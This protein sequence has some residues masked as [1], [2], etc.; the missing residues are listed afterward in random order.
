M[1]MN[2]HLKRFHI[3]CDTSGNSIARHKTMF[4]RMLS[5]LKSVFDEVDG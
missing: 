5:P 4:P 2:F 3:N 1:S